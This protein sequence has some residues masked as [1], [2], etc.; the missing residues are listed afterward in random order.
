MYIYIYV[1][2]HYK[3]FYIHMSQVSFS[4]IRYATTVVVLFPEKEQETKE[5]PVFQICYLLLPNIPVKV[6]CLICIFDVMIKFSDC[7]Q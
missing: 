6:A 1:Y 2:I 3:V 4:N 5:Y 7:C